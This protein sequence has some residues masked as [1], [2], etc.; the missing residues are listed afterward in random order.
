VSKIKTSANHL[1]PT[2]G[3]S[4]PLLDLAIESLPTALVV[5][6]RALKVVHRNPAAA[7]LLGDEP[8]AAKALSALSLEGRYTD[9]TSELRAVL[10]SRLSRRHDLATRTTGQTTTHLDLAIHPL[11]EPIAS[12]AV[13]GLILVEDVTA[14]LSMERR[15][16]GSE[17]L[18]AVGKLAA[19]VAHELNN[20]LDGALRYV[21]LA[22]RRAR[23]A[24]GEGDESIETLVGYLENAAGGIGRMRDIVASLLDFSRS[25]P[26]RFEQTSLT[27][28]IEEAIQALDGK[29][30]E[31][32]VTVVGHFHEA[33]LPVARGGSLFQVFC[34]LIKNAIDAMPGG[35]TLT[36]LSLLDGPSVEVRFE[37]TGVGLPLEADRIFEPFFTTK[38]PGKG[39]GLGLAVCKELIERNGGTIAARQRDLCGTT[40][41]VRFPLKA[42]QVASSATSSH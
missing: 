26:S 41:I 28:I 7:K 16:A 24:R 21:N 38:P 5:F 31:G 11:L 20:P 39:T 34:N 9:W 22:L 32:R 40:M 6:S 2:G 1:A 8:D 17:K 15:L 23:E 19:R 14:R 4:T 27:K 10:D 18:A 37:D 35:G 36:I 33:D 12:R 42:Y 25:A 30:Q 13:G 29:I 3:K